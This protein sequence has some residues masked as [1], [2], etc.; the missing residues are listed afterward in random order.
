M[1]GKVEI[2]GL[3]Q[4]CVV[5]WNHVSAQWESQEAEL[6]ALGHLKRQGHSYCK[7]VPSSSGWLS[8]SL[9][10]SG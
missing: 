8:A 10:S 6:P 7:L 3:V 2:I 1:M 4:V 9:A 5:S